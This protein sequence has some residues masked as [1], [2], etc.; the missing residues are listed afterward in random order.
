MAKKEEAST[1]ESRPAAVFTKEQLTASK[2]FTEQQKDV[3]NG[4]L[5]NE[6][7]YTIEEVKEII[8]GFHKREVL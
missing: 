5:S 6:K 3:L 1:Q 4:L 2:Q 8:D 7:T